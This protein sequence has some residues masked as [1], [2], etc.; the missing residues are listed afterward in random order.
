M[1][2]EETLI[3]SLPKR[4]LTNKDIEKFVQR[5]R[6]KIP[7]FRGVFSRN[8]LPN[9]IHRNEC[10]IINLDVNSGPGT[11]WVAYKKRDKSILYFDS[12]GDLQPPTE[13]ITY[14]NSNGIC[15]I[16]YNHDRYQTF[17]STNCG[18]LCLMFLL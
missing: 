5:N 14:F 8:T 15:N 12:F 2:V 4:A 6:R 7:Y 1:K 3:R 10:G 11:H 17:N 16:F 9:T 13:I 18:H